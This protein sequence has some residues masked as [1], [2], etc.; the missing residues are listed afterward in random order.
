MPR[1]R[2]YEPGETIN[3]VAELLNVLQRGRYVYMFANGKPSHPAVV[4]Q[5]KLAAL[6]RQV[7]AGAIRRARVRD[8]WVA[9]AESRPRQECEGCGQLAESG[10]RLCA[11]CE[12]YKDHS[13]AI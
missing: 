9:W 1:P 4:R 13:G 5:Q 7:R 12:A 11:G 2:M 10:R 3:S 8:E 6:E